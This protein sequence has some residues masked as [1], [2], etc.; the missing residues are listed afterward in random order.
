MFD[1]PEGTGAV[2]QQQVRSSEHD[3]EHLD[4]KHDVRRIETGHAHKEE[5]TSNNIDRKPPD[6][7]GNELVER[8]YRQLFEKAQDADVERSKGTDNQNQSDEMQV[9]QNRPDPHRR[10]D[11]KML[12]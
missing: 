11:H 3:G 4:L 10:I 12:D 1:R 9:F 5:Q 2:E 6:S 7:P 8:R